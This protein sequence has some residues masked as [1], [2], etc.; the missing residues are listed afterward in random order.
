[1]ATPLW[2]EQVT[3]RGCVYPALALPILLTYLHKYT[4]TYTHSD[5]KDGQTIGFSVYMHVV[6]YA[7]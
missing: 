2:P 4:H 5:R 7:C 6:V 1:M 3:I